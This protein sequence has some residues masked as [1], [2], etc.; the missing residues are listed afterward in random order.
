MCNWNVETQVVIACIW[1]SNVII[2]R[3]GWEGFTIRSDNAG[4][5]VFLLS[6][7]E[8]IT[9]AKVKVSWIHLV[10][11]NLPAFPLAFIYLFV[12]L[13]IYLYIYFCSIH[14]KHKAKQKNMSMYMC[15]RQNTVNLVTTTQQLLCHLYIRLRRRNG[16]RW[17]CQFQSMRS[18]PGPCF[19]ISLVC[20]VVK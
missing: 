12:C 17:E 1:I 14:H 4:R 20:T 11:A 2:M 18:S 19:L 8:W 16:N 9:A 5:N 7:L 3:W 13:F 6:G 10:F 15:C